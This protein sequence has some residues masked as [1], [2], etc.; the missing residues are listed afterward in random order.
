VTW[1]DGNLL[2]LAGPG[3]GKTRVIVHRCAYLLLVKR[4]AARSILVLCFNRNAAHQIRR[5]LRELVG[6]DARGVQVHTYHGLA[7]RLTGRS[8]SVRDGA[9]VDE[10]L[11]FD[12]ILDDANRLLRGETQV[13]GFE[14]DELRERLLA[15]YEHVLVDE[16]QDID[17]RQYELVQ[18]IAKRAGDVE[19]E[20]VRAT[21]FAVGDDD[22]NIYGFRDANV[23]FLRRFQEDYDAPVEYL[24]ENY[25]STGHIVAAANRLIAANRD[26]MKTDARR[27][28]VAGGRFDA[29]D[30]VARGR[31]QL[32]RVRDGPSQVTALASELR[33]LKEL[34]A[35]ASWSDFA[36]L[37]R[38]HAEIAPFRSY[39]EELGVPVRR[40]IPRADL[41]PL[42]RFREIA[43][44]LQALDGARHEDLT[45]AELRER[46]RAPA[47]PS[48]DNTW[49]RLLDELLR[50]WD[51]ETA[52]K[53]ASVSDFIAFVY[54][55][56]EEQRRGQF[57]GD[58]V[59]LATVHA[60]KGTEFRHVFLPDGGWE[61]RPPKSGE[62]RTPSQLAEEERRTYYV[63]LTRA[64]ETLC[65]FQRAD[66]ANPHLRVM[67]DSSVETRTLCRD[68]DPTYLLP[69]DQVLRR[70]Y[71]LLGFH[72]LYLDF[73]GR[74]PADHPIHRQLAALRTGDPLRLE[75]F[76]DSVAV[77]DATGNTVAQ[78]SQKARERWRDALSA[79]ESVRVFAIARRAR[80]STKDEFRDAIRTDEW[81][82]PI[83]EVVWRDAAA[84]GVPRLP[85]VR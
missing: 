1:D 36:I 42:H 46:L 5:R 49:V 85:S 30:A 29:L 43:V 75:R 50:E 31:V 8:L 26:R 78:L 48:T 41:P 9:A 25:R 52:G 17:R 58:G 55:T 33:R 24:V 47:S 74:R 11:D 3:S 38:S 16:Y 12:A 7:L 40:A 27:R 6:D 45:T 22:Q 15:G 79:V 10:Q 66:C 57:V 71:D 80:K 83:V 67:S 35:D 32:V 13:A 82:I 61:I 56:L 63:A 14:P 69:P 34:D 76:G 81:E 39:F 53:A 37:A 84:E 70:R 23:E 59:F 28:D 51:D 72:D 54:E 64:K 19:Q 4:V 21:L 20:S 18:A 73:A 62:R 65:L 68:M 60:A 44:A 77:L 2:V